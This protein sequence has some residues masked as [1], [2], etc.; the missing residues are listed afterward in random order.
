MVYLDL[1]ET[2]YF[3]LALFIVDESHTLLHNFH[4]GDDS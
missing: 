1:G 2:F 4:P 3:P